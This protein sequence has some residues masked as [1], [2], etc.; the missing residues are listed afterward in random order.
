MSAQSQSENISIFQEALSS[1]LDKSK[2]KPAQVQ[3]FKNTTLESLKSCIKDIQIEQA[4]GRNMR[5]INRIWPFIDAM[6]QYGKIIE[7][8]LNMSGFVAFIW[9]ASKYIS[10]FDIILDEYERLGECLPQ[11]Q[12]Y[13]SLFKDNSHMRNVL[14]LVYQ[15]ILEFH[16]HALKIIQRPAWNIIFRAA[17]KDLTNRL[18]QI[19]EKLSWHKELIES[20]ASIAEFKEAKQARELERRAF[21]R[22]E[23][24]NRR[25]RMVEIT[26]WLAAADSREDQDN[27]EALRH[28]YPGTGSWVLK[29]ERIKRWLD[30]SNITDTELWLFG[31]P[32]AG[33]TVLTSV[34]VEELEKVRASAS[35]DAGNILVAVAY[36]YCRYRTENKDNFNAV[37]RGILSHLIKNN[38]EIMPLVWE[39][40]ACSGEMTLKS[41]KLLVE[42]LEVA[43]KDSKPSYIV[44]DG[45]DECEKAERK[46]IIS[47][48][49][50]ITEI[51]NQQAPGA[52]HLLFVSTA[53]GDIKRQLSNFVKVQLKPC[54]ADLRQYTEIW[55]IKIQERFTLS[56]K[57]RDD[58]VAK[59]LE[60]AHGMLHSML[61]SSARMFLYCS[62]VLKH[63]HDQGSR[64]QLGKELSPN[65]FPTGLEKVYERIV[66]RIYSTSNAQRQNAA[67]I[68]N[69][70]ACAKRP[71]KKH[72][73]QAV[74]AIGD[75]QEGTVDFAERALID[76]INDLCGS[77]IEVNKE[78]TIQF[79]HMTARIFLTKSSYVH[80][81]SAEA[82]LAHLCVNYL[83]FNCF[84]WTLP[85]NEIRQ[86]VLDGY[87]SFQDYAALYW[88]DH[89]EILCT[90]FSANVQEITKIVG[91]LERFLQQQLNTESPD[92]QDIR[93]TQAVQSKFTGLEGF[94]EVYQGLARL[95]SGAVGLKKASRQHCGH[96]CTLGQ[97]TLGFLH[98]Q[99]HIVKSRQQL[100]QVFESLSSLDSQSNLE[101]A[102]GTHWFKCRWPTCV[103]FSEG[104]TSRQARDRH[105]TRHQRLFFCT[106]NACPMTDFGCC[107]LR[108]LNAHIKRWHSPLELGD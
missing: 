53:E 28:A 106:E 23:D 18:K 17:W 89:I 87:F 44:I 90:N 1:F 95:A 15:D 80:L 104:F 16:S 108:E 77:F 59:V 84:N 46:K 27:F 88:L 39:K 31:K 91:P 61:Y 101:Q 41:S 97:F 30:A 42:L 86:F 13:D 105:E 107:T 4:K 96:D 85:G 82:N 98:L 10:C 6:E 36:F 21:E 57:E 45:L 83:T 35:P 22:E 12:Q 63:L 52:V 103:H 54:D 65:V 78:G 69:L 40:L 24:E 100:E 79:V 75:V 73:V 76:D 8:F 99:G 68:L 102:Y 62:I 74:F 25:R 92:W 72:E 56:D 66:G 93:I 5:N 32:G 33:K 43:I 67:Q 14:G 9:V 26:N 3:D 47:T 38:E 55:G 48:L 19:R 49:K 58:L 70:I 64:A 20:Q 2:L 50:S 51:S 34:I 81:P 94:P 37:G 11:F 71:L 29:D 60:R 7:V